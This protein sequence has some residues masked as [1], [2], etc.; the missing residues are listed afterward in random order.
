MTIYQ[1]MSMPTIISR[2]S[3]DNEMTAPKS[4]RATENLAGFM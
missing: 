4:S 3:A 1:V 2:V